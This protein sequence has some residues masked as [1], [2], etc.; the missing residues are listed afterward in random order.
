MFSQ[1]WFEEL[2]GQKNFSCLKNLFDYQKP[3]NFLEIGCFEG[4]CHLWMYQNLLL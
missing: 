4:N 3:I 2:N 1:H